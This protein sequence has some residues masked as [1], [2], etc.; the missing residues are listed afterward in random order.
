MKLLV[1]IILIVK[2]VTLT[3]FISFH[4]I[5]LT[6]IHKIRSYNLRAIRSLGGIRVKKSFNETFGWLA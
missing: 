4:E 1:N 6:G 2:I 5:I 3:K